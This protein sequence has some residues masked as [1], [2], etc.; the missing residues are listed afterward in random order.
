VLRFVQKG[1]IV[2]NT[3]NI[4]KMSRDHLRRNATAKGK[5]V[6]QTLY[7]LEKELSLATTSQNTTRTTHLL[8]LMK[9][10]DDAFNSRDFAG[11]KATHH[12][13]IV[14]HIPGSAEPIHGQPAHA[15][16]IKEM[17]RIFPDVHVYNDPYPIQFGSGDRTTV[18]TR[19]TGTF[20]GEMILP[21]GKV[22]APT[23]KVFDLAFATTAK[24]DGDVLLEEFVSMDSALRAQQIG[25]A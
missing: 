21:G 12:P 3:V 24:W 8:A 5:H 18:I 10:G 25:L 15:A 20:S 1:L 16:M 2:R 11:M 19:A 13:E 14:G 6:P 23:G 4:L 7:N 9:K 22:I 17:F